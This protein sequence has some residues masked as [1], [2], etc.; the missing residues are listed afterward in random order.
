MDLILVARTCGDGLEY[1]L[2]DK[3]SRKE[4]SRRKEWQST[5]TYIHGAGHGTPWAITPLKSTEGETSVFFSSTQSHKSS[6]HDSFGNERWDGST[7]DES[8]RGRA[9]PVSQRTAC[10]GDVLSGPGIC[11]GVAVLVMII[12]VPCSPPID[13]HDCELA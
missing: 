13:H 12:A 1:G 8:Q 5:L 6:V 9:G 4:M 11:R 2:E 7:A 3:Q 10:L